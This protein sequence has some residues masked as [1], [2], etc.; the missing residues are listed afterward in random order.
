MKCYIYF[1]SVGSTDTGCSGVFGHTQL[2]YSIIISIFGLAKFLVPLWTLLCVLQPYE[3]RSR[4]SEV[5]LATSYNM[6]SLL[7]SYIICGVLST[8]TVVLLHC[9][10]FPVLAGWYITSSISRDGKFSSV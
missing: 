10:F 9:F 1:L 3:D 6:V 8:L 2:F 4:A 5:A 7:Q